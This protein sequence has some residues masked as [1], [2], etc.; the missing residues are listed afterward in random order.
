LTPLKFIKTRRTITAISKG[1]F[2]GWADS[3]RKLKI[4]SPQETM[5]TVIVRM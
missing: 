3:G 5:D 1:I 4:A 2:P